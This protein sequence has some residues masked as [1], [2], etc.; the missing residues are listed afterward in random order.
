MFYKIKHVDPPH[1]VKQL[2][3]I[4]EEQHAHDILLQMQSEE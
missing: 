1:L 3:D 2:I 4:N